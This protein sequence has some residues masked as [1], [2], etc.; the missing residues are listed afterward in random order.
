MRVN[1][2]LWWILAIFFLAVETP[3]YA[4]WSVLDK[5]AIE[6]IGTIALGCCGIFSVLLG[7]YLL[8][9]RKAIGSALPE[10]RVDAVVDDGDPE[11]GQFSPWSWWPVT[12]AGAG[13]LMMLGLAV[14]IWICFIGAAVL[15][16]AI[17]G[18]TYEYYRGHFAR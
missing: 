16:V 4:V 9:L 2:N 11:M 13:A 5:G 12:L 17:V 10:D 18:W 14:G 15:L 6:W 8:R 7:F 3:L 1:A